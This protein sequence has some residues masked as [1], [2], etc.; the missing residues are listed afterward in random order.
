[1]KTENKGRKR[2]I[3]T[4]SIA[5]FGALVLWMYAIGYD[6]EIDTKTYTGIVVEIDGVNTNGYTVA[7]GDSFSLAVD[8]R[9]AGTRRVL[10]DI[11]ADDLSAYVDISSVSG[12]G[13]TTLPV[14]VVAPNGSTVESISVPNV[15]LYV[16][17]FTSRTLEINIEKTFSSVYTIGEMTQSLYAISIYGPES[18][19]STAEAY[20]NI[21]LGEINSPSF[22]VS[23]EILLR[24]EE[25]KAAITN[26]YIT[27][28][29][30]SV[31][32]SFTM[33]GTKTV[34]LE[35]VLQGGTFRP[36]DVTFASS[37]DSVTLTGPLDLLS[38]V[39]SLYVFCDESQLEEKLL[40]EITVE[41]LLQ[42]NQL[43]RKILPLT[44]GQVISYSVDVPTI[45]F[46]TVTIYT[47]RVNFYNLPEDGSVSLE[48]AQ[49]FDITILGTRSSVVAYDTKLLSVY[50][51]YQKLE[52][53]PVTG[54]YKGIAEITTGDSSVCVDR[55]DY[56]V[57]VLVTDLTE[58]AFIG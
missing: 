21:S 12:P 5:L 36:E 1:M 25:T 32:L 6:T 11:D 46:E 24:D 3:F 4:F 47:S 16:D 13:L 10:G 9:L 51:D 2:N 54:F 38:H 43:E 39:D 14:K 34:P 30:T 8:V 40:A 45:R 48:C 42:S 49:D 20:T 23:G 7:D 55:D 28:S 18:I 31:E 37:V 52:L 50:V 56:L 35:L 19:I 57:Q 17:T 15:T 22:H 44:A 27:M 26:P 41:E 33:Y 58:P 29:S 53:D